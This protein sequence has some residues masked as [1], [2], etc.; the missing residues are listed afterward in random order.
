MARDRQVKIFP[1]SS[2]R[3]EDWHLQTKGLRVC[4]YRN[5]YKEDWSLIALTC[6]IP[7]WPILCFGGTIHFD[8]VIRMSAFSSLCTLPPAPFLRDLVKP[9]P[10]PKSTSSDPQKSLSCRFLVMPMSCFSLCL[11]VPVFMWNVSCSNPP[12]TSMKRSICSVPAFQDLGN[13]TETY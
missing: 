10:N 8:V 1:L 9:G 7:S 11:P 3:L 12:I 6:M 13:L 5:V 4:G 2:A